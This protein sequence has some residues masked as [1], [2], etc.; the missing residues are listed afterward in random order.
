MSESVTTERRIRQ[1]EETT[2]H[3]LNALE[4]IEQLLQEIRDGNTK[5]TTS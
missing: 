2:R 1:L 4:R 3:M 5:D